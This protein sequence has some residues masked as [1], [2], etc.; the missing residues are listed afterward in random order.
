M[1]ALT[2]PI[3][4]SIGD[5]SQCNK[6]KEKKG[7]EIGKEDLMLPL[8]PEDRMVYMENPEAS[9]TKLVELIS[10]FSKVKKYKGQGCLTGSVE[11][12]TLDLR[13]INSSPMLGGEIT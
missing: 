1:S 8:F 9:T 13:A 3:Q 12:E 6:A 4:H 10:K 2:I 11:H 5:T 7:N